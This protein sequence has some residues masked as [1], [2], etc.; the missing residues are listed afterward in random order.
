M[1]CLA[2]RR[3]VGASTWNSVA[4]FRGFTLLTT[5]RPTRPHTFRDTYDI[6][7]KRQLIA[8]LDP[9]L[10]RILILGWIQPTITIPQVEV[11]GRSQKV[12]LEEEGCVCVLFVSRHY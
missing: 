11:E 5:G 1:T 12:E 3:I 9:L 6:D 10:S 4:G 7:V 2:S 8:I